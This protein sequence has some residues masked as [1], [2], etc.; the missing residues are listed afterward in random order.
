MNHVSMQLDYNDMQ[1]YLTPIVLTL[2]GMLFVIR[3]N[4]MRI[5]WQIDVKLGDF[6]DDDMNEFY[7]KEKFFDDNEG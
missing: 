3:L 5:V 1:L 2:Q 7:K 6:D 4:I